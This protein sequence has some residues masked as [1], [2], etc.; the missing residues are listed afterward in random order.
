MCART[1]YPGARAR[2]LVKEQGYVAAGIEMLRTARTL[3]SGQDLPTAA[4]P[5]RPHPAGPSADDRP[6]LLANLVAWSRKPGFPKLMP[7]RPGARLPGTP[8][9]ARPR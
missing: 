7:G 1:V 9:L 6:A 8:R 2:H 5:L 3:A 4:R